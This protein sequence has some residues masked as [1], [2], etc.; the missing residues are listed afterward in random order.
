MSDLELPGLWMPVLE[1]PPA[2]AF[3]LNSAPAPEQAVWRMDLPA[4]P[5]QAGAVLAARDAQLRR[6]DDGFEKAEQEL[7]ARAN[8]PA[9]YGI[10]EDMS[11]QLQR[12][13]PELT[14]FLDR[15]L[16]A[17]LYYARVETA[18]G[19]QMIAET[20]ITWTGDMQSAWRE[21]TGP[22]QIALHAKTLELA[23]RS[24]LAMVRALTLASQGAVLLAGLPA[25][26]ATPG[27]VLLAL[28]AAWKLIQQVLSEIEQQQRLRGESANA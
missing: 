5:E 18:V 6:M 28:P 19:G 10:M 11:A 25:L 24:R 7:Q 23:C 17:V 16:V 13:A 20:L 27:G 2:V 8:A 12:A 1:A 26:L 9:S 15:A 14:A 4:D 22:E 21:G 3:D